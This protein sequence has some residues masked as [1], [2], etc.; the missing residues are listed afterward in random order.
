MLD[1]LLRNI[2]PVIFG[3]GLLLLIT[4][5]FVLSLTGRD[6][7]AYIGS[8]TTLIGLVVSSGLIAALQTRV[9]KNTNGNTSA[10]IAELKQWREA[11]NVKPVT[12]SVPTQRTGDEYAPPL[13]SEDTL[14][15][16]ES[17]NDRLPSHRS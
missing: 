4:F 2:V 11:Q 16:I 9:A 5:L 17:E 3:F 7:E 8:I 6:P 15:R 13:M 1:K 10:L 14:G 12:G